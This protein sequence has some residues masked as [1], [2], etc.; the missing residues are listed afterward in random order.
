MQQLIIAM[1]LGTRELV[2]VTTEDTLQTALD[3]I[4][5]SGVS[6]VPVLVPGERGT[7]AGTL[8]ESAINNAYNSAIVKH[9]IMSDSSK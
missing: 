1:D 5:D 3:R 9:E 4:T 2:T 8:T 6:Q 7:L